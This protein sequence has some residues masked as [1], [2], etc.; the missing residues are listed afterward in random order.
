[1]ATIGEVKSALP[2]VNIRVDGR[3]LKLTRRGSIPLGVT[4]AYETN[5]Q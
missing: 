2:G 4:S 1:M 3:S 5:E